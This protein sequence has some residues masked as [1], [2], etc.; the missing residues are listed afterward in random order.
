MPSPPKWMQIS[1]IASKKALT[2]GLRTNR[3]WSLLPIYPEQM[4]MRCYNPCKAHNQSPLDR[5]TVSVRVRPL[6][7]SFRAGSTQIVSTNGLRLA[8]AT[9]ATANLLPMSDSSHGGLRKTKIGS[10]LVHPPL[11]LSRI[12]EAEVSQSNQ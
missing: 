10:E 6:Y 8:V 2:C 5:A 7:R 4:A 9:T 12:R 11:L 3:Q 1:R